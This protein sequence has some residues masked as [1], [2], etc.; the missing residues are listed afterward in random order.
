MI[1]FTD[2]AMARHDP[3]PGFP[4]RSARWLAL[5]EA[6]DG[7]RD[8]EVRAPSPIDRASAVAV[9][10]EGYVDALFAAE[11]RAFAVD[12]ETLGSAESVTA[13]R[14]A[15]GAAREAALAA[16]DGTR[17]WALVRPPGHHATR[18]TGMGFC[19]LNH[20]V[21]A[22]HAARAERGIRRV[23][24]VDWDVHHG[25]G[26]E[27]LV[28]GDPDTL[29]FGTHQGGDGFYPGT[30][31][32][33][34]DNVLNVPLDP[35]HGDAQM[36]QAFHEVLRPAA[37]AFEPEL[38]LVSAGFDA[39]ADDPLAGLQATTDGFATLCREVRDLADTL[40]GGRLALTLEGGY[41][42]D[43]LKDCVTACIDVLVR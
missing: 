7:R 2:P 38:V 39:H 35:G 27:D 3:G 11:G 16:V 14:L 41:D 25:N 43:A 12:P 5:H 9:H 24:I 19:F 31:L 13:I 42:L 6:I 29:F 18:R 33:S 30:G 34:R 36:L 15:S 20:V 32:V 4:E 8:V 23:L 37:E 1:V 10:D 28:L 22:A 21:I 26:T 40:A 17:A